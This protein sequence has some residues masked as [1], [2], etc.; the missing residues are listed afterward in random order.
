MA[1]F[2]LDPRLEATS[3]A[4]TDLPLCHVRLA[5]D[6]RWP[7]LVLV[8]RRPGLVEIVDLPDDDRPT[9]FDESA[10]AAEAVHAIGEANGFKVAKLNVG[11]LGNI[12]P[13][14]HV[15]VLGRRPGDPAWPG[16]VWGVGDGRPYPAEALKTALQAARRALAGGATV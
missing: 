14:L 8:P 7:W 3:A 16:P 15:H 4:V 5:L 12:V 9:L 6:A 13:Q 2:I 10:R 11:A 1:P